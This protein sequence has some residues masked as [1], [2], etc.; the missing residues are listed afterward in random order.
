MSKL[1][2]FQGDSISDCGRNREDVTS[3]GVGYVHMVKGELGCEC[4]GEYE[5]INKGKRIY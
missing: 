2:V 4:P 5:F 3:T 1:I